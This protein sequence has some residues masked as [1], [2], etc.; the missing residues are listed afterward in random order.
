MTPDFPQG[1]LSQ[2]AA[3]ARLL[4]EDPNDL[5]ANSW[6][7]SLVIAAEVLREPMFLFLLD[8]GA[9]YFGLSAF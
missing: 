4:A 7:N 8:A 1:L 3:T 5:G 2:E 6:R 9:I